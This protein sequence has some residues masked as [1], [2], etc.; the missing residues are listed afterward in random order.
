MV[1]LNEIDGGR[2]RVGEA[3]RD[4]EAEEGGRRGVEKVAKGSR[5]HL[6]IAHSE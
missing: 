4:V 1:Q 5:P 6:H 3:T 2:A